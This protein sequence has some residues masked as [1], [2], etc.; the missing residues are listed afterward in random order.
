[1]FE[2]WLSVGIAAF[3]SGLYCRKL[4]GLNEY[5]YMIYQDMKEVCQY[6]REQGPITLDLNNMAA[7]NKETLS[8]AQ[9]SFRHHLIGSPAFLKMLE[10][11][12]HLVMRLIDD[13]IGR[14]IM[15]QLV[16]KLLTQAANCVNEK[17]YEEKCRNAFMISFEV[18]IKVK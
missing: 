12:A 8:K 18:S 9:L 10:K 13:Q 7:T 4:L 14:D 2:W 15:L 11:K 5:K 1:M 17:P 6:E 16:N 3:F